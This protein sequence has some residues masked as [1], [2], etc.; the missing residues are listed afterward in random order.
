MA[1][2]P[3]LN[4]LDFG[5]TRIEDCDI[6]FQNKKNEHISSAPPQNLGANKDKKS[7]AFLLFS[8]KNDE[9][10]TNFNPTLLTLTNTRIHNFFQSIR[11]GHNCKININLI[12]NIRDLPF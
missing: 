7:V 9:K 2:C 8:N 3:Y 12:L 10:N 4:Y 6:V 5:C 11:A 1:L